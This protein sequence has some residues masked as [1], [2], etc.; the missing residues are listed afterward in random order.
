MATLTE[1][2]YVTRRAIKFAA[3]GVVAYI[4]LRIL[5]AVFAAWWREINPPPPR[6]PTLAFGKLPAIPFPQQDK[7]DIEFRLETVTGTTGEFGPNAKVFV[8]PPERGSLLALERATEIAKRLEFPE[9]SER[10]G[11]SRY[12]FS[13]DR[14]LPSTLEYDLVTGH[15]TFDANWRVQPELLTQAEALS[16]VEAIAEARSWLS[17]L[18]LLAPDLESGETLVTYLRVS[19][20]ELVPALSQSEAQFVRVDLFRANL[21]VEIPKSEEETKAKQ[22][23][24]ETEKFRIIP[25]EPTRGIVV[26]VILKQSRARTQVINGEYRYLPIDYTQ[27]A[28]Y[29]LISSQEAWKRLRDGKAYYAFLPEGMRVI[30]VRR[31][32][33]AYLDPP[34]SGGYL[35]P[36]YVFEG[37]QGFLGY[38]AAIADEQIQE[39]S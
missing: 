19:G 2:A 15:F 30:A 14:P 31:V 9:Q 12:R 25:L 4:V 11:G 34:Q 39:P 3:I 18:R 8:V 26:V 5:I 29:P 23:P 13:K 7:P 16:E 6:P 36:I 17:A 35:Q 37:D 38:V 20:T 24:A 10:I 1:A 33:L 21:E 28:T 32:S 22:K 27:E